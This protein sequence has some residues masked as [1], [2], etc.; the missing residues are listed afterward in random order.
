MTVI[1]CVF[2]ELIKTVMGLNSLAGH[3]FEITDVVFSSEPS[4]PHNSQRIDANTD[5]T[6]NTMKTTLTTQTNI[7]KHNQTQTHHPFQHRYMATPFQVARG[8][9]SHAGTVVSCMLRTCSP[10]RYGPQPSHSGT[11]SKSV[12]CVH[13]EPIGRA[14]IVIV[15]KKRNTKS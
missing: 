7:T 5:S 9:H 10:T 3:F 14:I 1:Q 13:R 11:Q 2:F 6:N 12:P 15:I 4:P 8:L